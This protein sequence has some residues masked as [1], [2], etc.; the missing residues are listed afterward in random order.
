MELDL[1]RRKAL[2]NTMVKISCTLCESNPPSTLAWFFNGDK[3][4]L[5]KHKIQIISDPCQ[6]ALYFQA[7]KER[8]GSYMCMATNNLGQAYSTTKLQVFGIN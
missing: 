2:T 4:D 7:L 3:L 8:E 1:Y 5:N 6:E